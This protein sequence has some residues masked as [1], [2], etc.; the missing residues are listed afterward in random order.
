[1]MNQ[2]QS[3][4]CDRVPVA[5]HPRLYIRVFGGLDAATDAAFS[6]RVRF[7][8]KKAGALLAYLA[9]SPRQS[10]SRDQIAGLLWGGYADERAR[11]S[12]R[13]ALS[14]LRRDLGASD[15]LRIEADRVYLEPGSVSVDAVEFAAL[16]AS[17]DHGELRK[18]V[19][20]VQGEILAGL[21]LNE[22]GFEAWVR[23]QRRH[24]ETTGTAALESYARMSDAAGAGAE[25]IATAERLVSLDPLRED[26]L[27]LALL[28]Y[29]RHRGRNEALAQARLLTRYL[30]R[31]LDGALEEQTR[32][33]IARIERGEV[34]PAGLPPQTAPV[35]DDPAISV[36]DAIAPAAVMRG[37]GLASGPSQQLSPPPE[38]PIARTAGLSASLVR[39]WLQPTASGRWWTHSWAYVLAVI[40]LAL[41][42]GLVRSL[43]TQ[44]AAAP[45]TSAV[46]ASGGEAWQSPTAG[47]Q[48]PTI[49]ARNAQGVIPVLVL[50]FVSDPDGGSDAAVLALRVSGDLINQLSRLYRFRVISRNTAM[51]F[52]GV[53]VDSGK[54]GADLGVRYVVEGS[55]R[56]QGT[57]IRINVELID[58]RTRLS[59]WSDHI[60]HESTSTDRYAVADE[61]VIRVARALQVN[62]RAIEVK[63]Q[64]ERNA[65]ATELSDKAWTVMFGGGPTAERLR[66]GQELFLEA[67][68]VQPNSMRAHLGLAAYHVE[69]VAELE[70]G[71]RAGHV[72]K[73]FEYLRKA[74][75][76]E[77]IDAEL[78]YWL[79]RAHRHRDE[80]AAAL[81][82]FV[83]CL[84]LNPSNVTAHGQIGLTLLFDR[85]P[86]EALPHIEYAM[87]LGPKDPTMP[88]LLRFAAEAELEI[89]KL[90]EA[91]RHIELS[92]EL[93][94]NQ[95]RT[96]GVLAAVLALQNRAD[97]LPGVV[98]KVRSLGASYDDER[99][100]RQISR[101]AR[102]G[103][104]RLHEG[105]KSALL[106]APRGLAASGPS[107][108]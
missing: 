96:W 49:S 99:L 68:R 67:L 26:W 27:R 98:A 29:A 86:A 100:L 89:G 10:A 1:M 5:S 94:P 69:M 43:Y 66:Q 51:T 42:G 61:I 82:H 91:R 104:T 11:H 54:V 6:E 75:A 37:D 74:Q 102:V 31:E 106:R 79:G 19:G 45:A 35:S 30:E 18:A 95:L 76:I 12:V 87:R 58:T 47:V 73:A 70:P 36:A 59:A 8:A 90:A 92:I 101:I 97:K 2:R 62:A 3:E 50:P 4:R 64:K 53:N 22:E 15:V 56:L 14:S 108:P 52:Q 84:E 48:S 9:L 80:N 71:D 23:E 17:A 93:S 32:T 33:L 105:L 40:V 34:A 65:S 55:L 77:P 78:H 57:R 72:A 85:K 21:Q 44:M 41:L 16:A 63:H 25:A 107:S 13:Q 103:P 81:Q 83:R 88:W 28:I 38:R 7:S 60:V 24:F 46:A 39:R 20:L